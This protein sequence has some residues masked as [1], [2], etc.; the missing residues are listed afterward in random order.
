[1]TFR[2]LAHGFL[3]LA[4]VDTGLGEKENRTTTATKIESGKITVNGRLDEAVWSDAKWTSG[5]RQYEPVAGSPMTEKTEFAIL[6]TPDV[7]YLGVRCHDSEPSKIIG[8]V[9]ERDGFLFSDD[10]IYFV[11]DSFH[12]QRNGYVFS[13]NPV[14]GRQDSL[15]GNNSGTDSNWDTIW[16]GK[17]SVDEEGWKAEIGIPFKSIS[18][19]PN[20]SIWGF[21]ISRTIRRS[22]ERG[23]WMNARPEIRTSQTTYAGDI[24]GLEGMRQGIGLQFSP[25]VL[26]RYRDTDTDRDLLGEAGFDLR[27]RVTPGLSATFSYN[28]DF[29]QTEVDNRQLNFSRFP[30]FFPEKR[31]FFL[32][33][34]N[35]YN[36]GPNRSR[37]FRTLMLPY[38]S[39]RI[40]L[41]DDGDVV[42][43]H[44]ATKVSGRVGDYELGLTQAFLD[45][46]HHIDTQ[47]VFAGRISRRVGRESSVGVLGTAGDPNSNG[48]SSTGGADLRYRTSSLFGDKVLTADAWVLGS[49][50]NPDPNPPIDGDEEEP[51]L[52]EDYSGYA[53]GF[54]MSYPNEPWSVTA[55]YNEIEDSF[56]P[57]LGYTRRSGIRT[58]G[59]YVAFRHRPSETRWYRDLRSSYFQEHYWDF[60]GNVDSGL[61]RLTLFDL[62]LES[63]DEISFSINH[64][65]DNPDE[66]FDLVDAVTVPADDYSWTEFELGLEFTSR[67]T[68]GGEVELSYGDFYD[69]TRFQLGMELNLRPGR[70]FVLG[71]D[72]SYNN[73]RLPQGEF[74][75][76]LAAVNFVWQFS[77]E[78]AW[79]NLVQYDSVSESIGYFSRIEWEYRPGSNLYLVINQLAE[80][81][82]DRSFHRIESDVTCKVGTSI[83]F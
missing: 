11:F 42:P 41:S 34:S 39:R 46:A 2:L 23:R 15:A 36:F 58:F 80:K 49:M 14:G 72:Y 71:L 61:H 62:E 27:Y 68:L 69:G 57:A 52:T 12:D 43:V 77:P 60:D 6:Y 53:Y 45:G 19:D 8:R 16:S 56:D 5:L 17:C 21:N 66:S 26:G 25:Y 10:Y 67:R 30:L 20:I 55:R 3:L 63:A 22:N 76:H 35:L 40:G 1:M 51:P 59:T 65:T 33:D 74:Q 4:V 18:F 79:T 48:D 7:L 47:N 82:D 9:M 50:T 38:F 24:L 70:H 73:V 32:Q 44:F 13:V 28:T 29:A 81:K 54:Q 64:Q 83:R 37:I 78:L 31:D 75:T